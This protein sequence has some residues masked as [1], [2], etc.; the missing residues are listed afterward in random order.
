MLDYLIGNDVQFACLSETWFYDVENFQTLL[1]KDA[2]SYDVYNRPRITETCGGGVTILIKK[3]YKSILQ[4]KRSFRSFE[5]IVILCCVSNLPS[6]KLRIVSLYR[7]DA[8]KFSTFIQEFSTFVSELILSKYQFIIGGDFNTHMN[9]PNH[10][11]TKRFSKLCRE[12][13]L[14]LSNVPVSATHI[15]GNTIDFIVTDDVTATMVTKC[16]VDLNVPSS[17]SHHYPVL[18][19]LHATLQCRSIAI[20]KPTRNFHN[21]NIKSFK[22]ELAM[23]LTDITLYT[24]FE[25][26]LS[27][28]QNTLRDC[29]DKHVPLVQSKIKHNERPKWMDHDY[30]Q[31]RALR[32]K[33]E[34]IFKRTGNEDDNI[35]FKLQ[36]TKC[37]LLVEQKRDSYFTVAFE[38]CKGNSKAIF[39]TYNKVVGNS[40]GKHAHILPDLDDY[41]NDNFKLASSFNQYFIEKVQKARD[42]IHNELQLIKQPQYSF[43][44]NDFINNSIDSTQYLSDFEPCD[45]DELK[46]IIREHGIKTTL[47]IDLV[48]SGLM[49]EC[50]DPLLPHLLDLVNTSLKTGSIDGVKLAYVAPLIKNLTDVDYLQKSSYRPIS[51]LSFISKLVERVVAKR[52]NQHMTSNSLHVDSQHGYKAGHSTETL[53]VK[54]MND[55]LV[56]IDKN[57]GIVV[58]LVDLSSAFDT[59]QHD[60]LMKI[61]RDSLYI[62]GTA[63]KWFQS[64]LTG[65]TQAVV[66]NGVESEW[67]SVSCGVPQGSV[68][69]PILFNIYCRHIHCVFEDCGFSSSSYADDNSAIKTFALFN[70]VNTLFDDIP[71]CISKLKMYM[72]NHYLKLNDSKTEIIVFGSSKFKDQLTLNGTFLD[73]G[74]CIR[75]TDNVK[76]LG[77]WFDS[78]LDMDNQIQK[79]VSSSYASLRKI[80]SMRKL[81]KSNLEILVHAFISSKLDSCNALY[82][83]LPK[84]SL[85]KL[86]KLQNAAIRVICNVRARHPV[87]ELYTRLH[88]LNV[89]QRI[90]YKTLLLVYKCIHGL[91]PKTLK[92]MCIL[93]GR[94]N[95]TLKIAF[96]NKTKYGKR[97]FVY[98]A[99]RYWNNLPI[100]LRRNNKINS[101]KKGLKSFL[102]LHFQ[103]FKQNLA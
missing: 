55:I 59:V 29:Y 46:N 20:S 81:S 28:F 97:A 89:E 82:F 98:Y 62:R 56:A 79:V 23:S 5:C 9:H 34:R 51:N 77:V 41:D 21:F 69:G 10:S 39:D 26:K 38:N 3:K 15:A 17:I 30:V 45:L 80:S 8:I 99:P 44:D 16:S 95:L 53:L 93:N 54:F 48:S 33:L 27:C 11:Y 37:S 32:R 25:D 101:F 18:Y 6:Q 87:S 100:H 19:T 73:S 72:N 24:S 91:A 76:Y 83:G 36:R 1:L 47:K 86:Q 84:K 68:L 12:L 57:R 90:C 7:R 94:D 67:L 64:F 66:I 75:F 35:R 22:D 40:S 63:L 61:L 50:V 96:F 85:K 65:R 71:K 49:Q 88:W 13:N 78:L 102:I 42:C 31:Q 58:L 92:D 52:L 43:I 74:Q 4:K 60:I 103:D 14:N 2:G 70:Q